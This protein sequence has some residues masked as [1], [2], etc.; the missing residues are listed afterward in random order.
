MLDS[1][2][3]LGFGLSCSLTLMHDLVCDFCS[4]D[5]RFARSITPSRTSSFLQILSRDRHPCLRLYPSHCRADWGLSPVRSVRP[6]GALKKADPAAT[7]SAFELDHRYFSIPIVINI[8]PSV[9]QI[10]KTESAS[11]AQ[12]KTGTS[13]WR[14][15]SPNAPLRF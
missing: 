11:Q 10:S 14:F 8:Q 5:R 4:S 1:V 9:F 7:E 3:L 12:R 2:Q 15:R 13:R 6:P